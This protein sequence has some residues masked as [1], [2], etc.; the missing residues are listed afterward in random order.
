MCSPKRPKMEPL[1][2]PPPPTTTVTEDEAVLREGQRERRRAASRK[3][4]GSTILAGGD[5]DGGM[6]PTGQAKQ[7]L[8]S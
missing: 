6:A 2:I 1:P 3:G 5:I 8:G 7:L 4:R